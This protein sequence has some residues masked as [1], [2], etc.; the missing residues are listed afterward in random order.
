MLNTWVYAQTPLMRES[1]LRQLYPL[2]SH[3]C[4][5]T[6][7]CRDRT[8]SASGV[9]KDP[10]EGLGSKYVPPST[11]PASGPHP[12]PY[13]NPTLTIHAMEPSIA[14]VE[15]SAFGILKESGK[16]YLKE[17]HAKERGNHTKTQLVSE[18]LGALTFLLYITY[19]FQ[20]YHKE[21]TSFV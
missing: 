16:F 17:R 5:G 20:F 6:Q 13:P 8:P 15:H 14:P 7:G 10:L 9:Q 21:H 12:K 1:T 4:V 19:I 11:L 3:H 2:Y 18:T